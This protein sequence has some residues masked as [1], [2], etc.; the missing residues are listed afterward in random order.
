[1]AVREAPMG[2]S[3]AEFLVVPPVL[4]DPRK[5]PRRLLGLG[6]AERGG[7]MLAQAGLQRSAHVYALLQWC[8]ERRRRPPPQGSVIPFRAVYG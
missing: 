7:K 6:C 5:A 3:M 2:E 1:M 8:P 4:R